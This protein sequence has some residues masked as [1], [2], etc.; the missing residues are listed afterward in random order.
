[1]EFDLELQF[2]QLKKI[3]NSST[4]I[5]KDN[6]DF[7]I[8]AID[9][10]N[11]ERI[12]YLIAKDKNKHSNVN[13]DIVYEIF[14]RNLLDEDR[15]IFIIENCSNYLNISTKLIKYLINYS[16]IQLLDI[17]FNNCKFFDN[18]FIINLLNYYKY[19]NPISTMKLTQLIKK[20]E[21]KPFNEESKYIISNFSITKYL[22]AACILG[23]ISAIKYF[24]NLGID[25]NGINHYGETSLHY[26][27]RLE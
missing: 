22:F 3:L 4:K 7:Y 18:D 11:V 12:K 19:K 27:C 17:I 5:N 16:Q 8:E 1:M 15:L 14:Q 10:G 9:L 20:Y 23:S 26:A 25:V 13:N 6:I 21:F 2:K 24:I